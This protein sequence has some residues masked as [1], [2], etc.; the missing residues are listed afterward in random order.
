MA[1]MDTDPD[2]KVGPPAA[3]R[4][5][6]P[7]VGGAGDASGGH[8]SHLADDS[9]DDVWT[10]T[11]AQKETMAGLIVIGLVG[12]AALFFHWRPGPTFLDRWGFSWIHPALSNTWWQHITYVRTM[13]FLVATSILSALVVVTRD[14]WRALAL[15]FGP[16]TATMLTEGVLKP[17]IG[18][19]YAEVYSFPSGTTTLVG[20]AATAW[21]IAV[22]RKIRL[23]VVVVAAFCAGLECM[24]VVAL[25]WHYPTD[26]VA[27]VAFGAGIVLLIDG[28]IHMIVD[29]ERALREAASARPGAA[30]AARAA[31]A[32]PHASAPAA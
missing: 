3:G 32:T 29:R 15:L 7:A 1:D 27:G 23:A 12:V 14:R 16:F 17:V 10:A 19:R 26:A 30:Q 20:A 11:G 4:E 9:P 25:Q 8:D 31:Q 5:A 18:R 22:P 2:I 21:V 28:V 6:E 13:S 24:A